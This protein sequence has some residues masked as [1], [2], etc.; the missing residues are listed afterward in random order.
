MTVHGIELE[1]DQYG[2]VKCGYGKKKNGQYGR[3]IPY[4]KYSESE[5]KKG[6]NGMWNCAGEYRPKQIIGMTY[7]GTVEWN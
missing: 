1:T 6:L 5:K 2:Y 7:R 3:L 4:H